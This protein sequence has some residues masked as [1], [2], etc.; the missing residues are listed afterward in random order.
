MKISVI[1]K[2][3]SGFLSVTE[4]DVQDGEQ[5]IVYELPEELI[6]LIR[7][8]PKAVKK[9]ST[10]GKDIEVKVPA[11]LDTYNVYLIVSKEV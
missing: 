6:N 10:T 5:L 11:W 3:R 7:N 9:D 2:F 1:P 8:P 4:Y